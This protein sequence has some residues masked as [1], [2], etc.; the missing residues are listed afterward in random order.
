MEIILN[1]CTFVLLKK[2][3]LLT[4][5]TPCQGAEKRAP[6]RMH[7]PFMPIWNAPTELCMRKYRIPID[8]SLFEIVGSTLPSA[9][10]QN[11]TLFYSDRLGYYPSIDH[12]TGTS[13]N[14]GIPQMSNMELHLKKAR[15]DILHYIPSST[16]KGLAIIDWEA[17]RPTW[18]RNWAS[19]AIY[20]KYSIDFAQQKDLTIDHRSVESKAKTQFESTAKQLMINTL[21]LGK[22]LRPNYLWGFYLFPNCHN[23]EYKQNSRNYSGKCPDI[24]M[25][26]NDK[27]RW[28]WKES[29]ALF[30]NMY[31]ETALKSS[32]LGALYTR[33]RI[34]EAK[35]LSTLSSTRYSLPIYVYSRPV[36]TDQPE[37]Y[38]TLSDLVNTI[39]ES[40]ALGAHGFIVW[41]SVNLTRSRNKCVDLNSFIIKTLNPYIINVSLS[42]RLCSAVLC[43]NNGV[44]IRKEWSKNTY[45][46]LNATNIAIEHYKSAYKV[47]GSLSLEDLRYYIKNFVCHCYAGLKCKAPDK[48]EPMNVCMAQ[49]I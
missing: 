8:V 19:K 41:G 44:C 24:E 11:I 23:Y 33:H 6:P 20:K 1:L 13:Y 35:R 12:E 9:T 38:L 10:N 15:E 2:L 4:L 31:L 34:Q 26:R 29:T 42:A 21:R 3:L 47:N 40:A 16:Q 39:G 17:W 46:H 14:G 25:L 49:S 32:Q 22:Q 5:T 28:L 30:P 37:K 7:S 43:Q 27:M 48:I 36:F 45:L 18:I